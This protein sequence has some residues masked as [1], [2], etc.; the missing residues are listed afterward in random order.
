MRHLLWSLAAL[1]LFTA[2]SGASSGDSASSPTQSPTTIA[3]PMGRSPIDGQYRVTITV[4]D[5]MAAGLTARQAGDIDGEVQTTFSLGTVRQFIHAGVTSDGF[6]GTFAVDGDQM[7]L[8]DN[9]GVSMTL[10]YV[11]KGNELTFSIADDPAPEPGASFDAA[12]WTSHP[13]VRR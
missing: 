3:A 1:V 2:C 5:G 7:V 8:T 12:L 11:L 10:G 9:G 4:K 13:F 6:M